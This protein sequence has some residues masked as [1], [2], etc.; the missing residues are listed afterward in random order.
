MKTKAAART[1]SQV[2][3][4]AG[5]ARYILRAILRNKAGYFFSFIF[6]LLFVIVFGLF[7]EPKPVVRL[8]VEAGLDPG[9]PLCRALR[10]TAAGGDSPVQLVE[11]S[12]RDLEKRLTQGRIAGIVAPAAGETGAALVTSAAN[13][14]GRAAAEGFLS[15]LVGEM[16]LRAA[17]ITQPAYHLERRNLA[18][19]VFR[20]IDFILPGQI[21]FSMLSL[22]TFGMAFSLT[23]LRRTLVLKRMLATSARPL[24]FVIAQ[25]LARSVQAMIQTA[26]IIAV[27]VALFH[28]SLSRGWLTA[29][30]ML[31][32]AFLGILTFLGFG[33]LIANIAPSDQTL[34]VVLNLFNLPQV[35]L[36]GVFFPIDAMPGWVQLIG[37]N[38]PLAYLNTSLRKASAEGASIPELWPYLLGM[39]AWAVVAYVLAART[40]RAE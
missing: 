23:T 10:E 19:R 18:G 27:G 28:F 8:G 5:L 31:V 2:R 14:Q 15:T 17:G 12:R 13:P 34:P 40:F 32:L 22:A 38:L 7:G 3:I 26:V 4:C 29:A 16:N 20:H 21:G 1:V 11:G 25:G 35:L 39:T 24:T 36:A 33:I 37:N 9:A 30:E 6:P